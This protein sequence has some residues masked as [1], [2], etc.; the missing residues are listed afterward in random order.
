MNKYTNQYNRF[1]ESI[2][3][4]SKWVDIDEQKYIE[5]Y[6]QVILQLEQVERE[7]KSI[8]EREDRL[9]V[10]TYNMKLQPLKDI[11]LDVMEFIKHKPNKRQV[12]DFLFNEGF[13]DTNTMESVLDE[14]W[15]ARGEKTYQYSNPYEER[16]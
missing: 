9:L 11:K 13:L 12:L 8:Q 7:R 10:E 4:L 1:K 3:D 6:R 5:R 16:G 14:M 2:K 15:N